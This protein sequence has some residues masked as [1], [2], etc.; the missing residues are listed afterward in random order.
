MTGRTEA[1]QQSPR[2]IP[3]LDAELKVGAGFVG[4]LVAAHPPAIGLRCGFEAAGEGIEDTATNVW[5]SGTR[6]ANHDR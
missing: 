2:G 3:D 1:G 6:A 5:G 4:N